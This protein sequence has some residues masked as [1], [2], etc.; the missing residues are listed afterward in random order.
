M[1]AW[2]RLAALTPSFLGLANTWSRARGSRGVA[3][4]RERSDREG[5][6]RGDTRVGFASLRS[7][8]R[9]LGLANTWSRAVGG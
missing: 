3:V 2:V 7:R 9:T 5:G 8:P 4:A 1:V 6:A